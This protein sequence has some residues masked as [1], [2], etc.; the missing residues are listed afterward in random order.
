MFGHAIETLSALSGRAASVHRSAMRIKRPLPPFPPALASTTSPFASDS[1]QLQPARTRHGHLTDKAS[2]RATQQTCW[3]IKRPN[4]SSA[5]AFLGAEICVER[6]ACV[7]SSLDDVLHACRC[8][9]LIDEYRPRRDEHA[10]SG[11][12]L[13][14][15]TRFAFSLHG[16]TIKSGLCSVC[17]AD[18][19]EAAH[20]LPLIACRIESSR[21]G[22]QSDRSHDPGGDRRCRTPEDALPS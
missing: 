12:S 10:L 2:Q 6:A 11:Q 22:G 4:I 3:R 1:V 20:S 14:L 13:S 16:I 18:V 9:S 15:F 19:E 21:S 7:A 5:V 8:K 17:D